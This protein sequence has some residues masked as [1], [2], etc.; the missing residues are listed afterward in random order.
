MVGNEFPKQ[1]GVVTGVVGAAGG[2]GGF[3]PPLLMAAV[4]TTFGNY[5]LGFLLLAF[6]GVICLAVLAMMMMRP[7]APGSGSSAAPPSSA[8]SG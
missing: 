7:S 5:T 2:L 8:K 3:F 4:K 6:T 1:V